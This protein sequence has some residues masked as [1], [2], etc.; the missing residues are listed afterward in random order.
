MPGHGGTGT[1]ACWQ[2]REEGTLPPLPLGRD[3]LQVLCFAPPPWRQRSPRGLPSSS[4]KH[5]LGSWWVPK[6]ASLLPYC[7]QEL[8]SLPPGVPHGHYLLLSREAS[9]FHLQF[10]SLGSPSS[11]FPLVF[12][13][14]L[15]HAFHNP[16]LFSSPAFTLHGGD[17]P[18]GIT[19]SKS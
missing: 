2:S 12:P 7:H 5:L 11:I 17:L 15:H 4:H 3:S 18:F 1:S 8:P 13:H 16:A 9:P 14:P 10:S 19:T 6:L